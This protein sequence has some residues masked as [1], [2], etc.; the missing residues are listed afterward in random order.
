MDAQGNWFLSEDILHVYVPRPHTGKGHGWSVQSG[1]QVC[2]GAVSLAAWVHA[3]CGRQL[4]NHI[5]D[6][7]F[8]FA[9]RGSSIDYPSNSQ[10]PK[11]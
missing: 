7:Q 11:T 2:T 10:S 1:E 8:F 3:L 9:S 4:Q 5:G 6:M